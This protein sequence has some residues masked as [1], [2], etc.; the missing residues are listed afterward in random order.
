LNGSGNVK[1]ELDEDGF[2]GFVVAVKQ[3][4]VAHTDSNSD[5]RAQGLLDFYRN[6]DSHSRVCGLR[7]TGTA[8]WHAEDLLVHITSNFLLRTSYSATPSPHRLAPNLTLKS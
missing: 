2:P 1:L 4:M 3:K 7:D 6:L 8:V 5:S